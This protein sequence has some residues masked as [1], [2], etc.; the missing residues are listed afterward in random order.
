METGL[1]SPAVLAHS[2]GNGALA[3]IALLTDIHARFRGEDAAP[4]LLSIGLSN[5][6]VTE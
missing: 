1:A 2:C 5:F 3:A 6:P 4:T